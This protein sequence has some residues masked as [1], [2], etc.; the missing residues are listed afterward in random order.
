MKDPI[1]NKTIKDPLLKACIKGDAAELQRLLEQGLKPVDFIPLAIDGIR[2]PPVL[3]VL[4]KHGLDP[5]AHFNEYQESLLSRAVTESLE[6]SFHLLVKSGARIDVRNGWGMTLLHDA[7]RTGRGD[8]AEFLIENGGD[9]NARS[10]QRH[11]PLILA[12]QGN[13]VGMMEILVAHGADIEAQ[14]IRSITALILAAK[15][16]KF[17]ATQWLVQH[18][19]NLNT[20]DDSGKTALDWAEANNRTKIVELLKSTRPF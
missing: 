5:N 2:K 6:P 13:Q 4:L 9:V 12:A 17:E 16:G 1:F 19:A 8:I 14:D 10:E 7:A 15:A 18:G 20:K 11:T 3:E